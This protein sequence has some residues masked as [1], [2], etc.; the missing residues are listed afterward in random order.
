[1][2]IE[3]YNII[4]FYI[5][6]CIYIYIF[7]YIYIWLYVYNIYIY[8]YIYGTEYSHWSSL[9]RVFWGGCRRFHHFQTMFEPKQNPQGVWTRPS[10][11][12]ETCRVFAAWRRLTICHTIPQLW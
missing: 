7:V 3:I 2:I 12:P 10:K 8:N 6:I 5:Y 1:L 4:C 11:S 9:I